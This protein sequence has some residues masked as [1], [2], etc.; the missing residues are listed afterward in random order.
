MGFILRGRPYKLCRQ[1][2]LCTK[3]KRNRQNQ[4]D[5]YILPFE[6]VNTDY[7]VVMQEFV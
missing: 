1:K 5:F 7:A 6:E 3:K 4:Y 2:G